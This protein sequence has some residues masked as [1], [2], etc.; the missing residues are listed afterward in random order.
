[1]S[2]LRFCPDCE[3]KYYHKIS[4]NELIYHCRVCGK[5]EVD[6]SQKT[7]C[8]L[9]IQYNK[10]ETKPFDFIVNKFTKYDPTLPHINIP[11]PNVKCKSKTDKSKGTELTTDAV[12]LR[13]D[14]T[15]M[16]HLYL[17]T[18]CDELWKTNEI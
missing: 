9:S 12:Y 15:H 11:C 1:M 13:Y 2:I 6:N 18:I 16:R 3:N 14:E 4:E 7:S 10:A 17:C 8:V 5:E